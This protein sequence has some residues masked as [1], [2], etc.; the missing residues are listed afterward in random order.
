MKQTGDHLIGVMHIDPQLPAPLYRQVYDSVRTAV[1]DGK[2]EP[3][4][5]LPSTRELAARLKLSRN[6]VKLAFELL[7]AEG[8]LLATIGSGTRVASNLPA[9]L[10]PTRHTKRPPAMVE[11]SRVP[12][13][14]AAFR[15]L[16]I[17][18]VDTRRATDPHSGYAFRS[19]MPALDAFPFEQ[20]G[21]LATRYY[22]QM[23]A[24]WSEASPVDPLG[25][26][27][28]RRAMATYLKATRGVQCEAEQVIVTTGTQQ[29]LYLAAQALLSAGDR[30]WI[31]DPG[32]LGAR[33]AFALSGAAITAVPVDGQGIDVAQGIAQAPDAR[34]V[35]VT[36]SH[37]FPIGGALSLERRFA[38]LRWADRSGAW[39]I[40]DDYDSE[41]RYSGYPIPALQGLDMAGRVIY[42]GSFNKVL[43]PGLRLGFLVAPP[44]LLDVFAGAMDVVSGAATVTNQV[45]LTH[46]IEG[47]HFQRHIRRMRLLYAER[48]AEFAR[49][50]ERHLDPAVQMGAHD[51]GMHFALYLPPG[52][53][54][55]RVVTAAAAHALETV[56]LARYAIGDSAA[57]KP[58]LLLGCCA[59]PEAHIQRK[60]ML[61]A[62]AIG[63]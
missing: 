37:Q 43:F 39:I 46:F 32:Y 45:V 21:R 16:R 40:E 11:P 48:V 3:G 14:A 15:G 19:G 12:A 24:S 36:P 61:L 51:A 55:E 35:Y 17:G 8:Y 58:G 6:T 29:G 62:Q 9:T 27:P 26:L 63:A 31:E 52:V 34:L 2:L 57:H 7:I 60:I 18:P 42:T 13:R 25:Y 54:A 4:L 50:A 49:Q 59:V 44:A 1:L 5:R 33:H 47:G 28:L 22:R 30:V 10:A 20:W 53:G 23:P 38:L 56:S 41:F